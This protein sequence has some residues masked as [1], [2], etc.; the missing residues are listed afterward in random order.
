MHVVDVAAA[1][2]DGLHERI[3]GRFGR[4]E[5][6][7]RVRKHV[8]GLLAGPGYGD[9]VQRPE[10]GGILAATCFALGVRPDKPGTG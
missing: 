3:A 2:L 7:A 10:V 8:S 9:W 6:R 1:E 5:P 4:S